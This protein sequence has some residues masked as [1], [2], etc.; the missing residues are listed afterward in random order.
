MA[1]NQKSTATNCISQS[2]LMP[3]VFASDLGQ[4][5]FGKEPA[6]A[7]EAGVAEAFALRFERVIDQAFAVAIE[8]AFVIDD[9]RDWKPGVETSEEFVGVEVCPKGDILSESRLVHQISI[10]ASEGKSRFGQ[11]IF[12]NY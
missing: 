8:T 12:A 4:F 10:A 11:Q 2:F 7:L 1:V 3:V 6:V 5:I 9:L